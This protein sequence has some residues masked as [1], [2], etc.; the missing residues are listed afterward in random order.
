M[1]EDNL[2]KDLIKGQNLNPES[3]S[4][5]EKLHIFLTLI[6]GIKNIPFEFTEKVCDLIQYL[7][8]IRVERNEVLNRLDELRNGDINYDDFLNSTELA[9]YIE[10]GD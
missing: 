9:D 4:I 2:I 5:V 10:H 6:L 8:P 7:S 3:F 1:E